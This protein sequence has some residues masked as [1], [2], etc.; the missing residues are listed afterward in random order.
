M[1]Y[2]IGNLAFDSDYL[3]HWGILGMKWGV[4]RYQNPDGSLTAEG[5]ERRGIG[6]KKETPRHTDSAAR[7]RAKQR[8][9]AL[10]AARKAKAEKAEYERGKAEALKRGSATEVMKYKGDLTSAQLND[11]INRIRNENTLAELVAKEAP[12]VKTG[13]DHINDMLGFFDTVNKVAGK[14]VDYTNTANRVKELFGDDGKVKEKER[15]KKI[16]SIIKS[17]D[18]NAILENINSMTNSEVQAALNRLNNISKLNAYKDGTKADNK[19]ESIRDLVEEILA[20]R[21]Q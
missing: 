19:D 7:K 14:L 21:G 20:S 1:E 6:D 9:K 5:R 11:A 17:G 18:L 10:E 13:K 16:E 8:A 2:H 12:K 15:A 3:E 4:R